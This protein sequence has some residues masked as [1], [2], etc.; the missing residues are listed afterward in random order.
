MNPKQFLDMISEYT[1]Y[2]DEKKVVDYITTPLS[3]LP[4]DVLHVIPSFAMGSDGEYINGL[5]LFTENILCEVRLTKDD[6]YHHD[7]INIKTIINIR[8]ERKTESFKGSGEP[9]NYNYISITLLHDVGAFDFGSKL[10]YIGDHPDNW[11]DKV[12]DILPIS[13]LI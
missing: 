7:Y 12:N 10:I 8:Y 11:L 13:L 5:F 1:D 2:Y 4:E 6:K 3:L 9:V